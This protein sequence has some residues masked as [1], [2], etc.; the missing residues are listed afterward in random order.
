MAGPQPL[1]SK[2]SAERLHEMD[3]MLQD[4]SFARCDIAKTF[5]LPY[6]SVINRMDY[7][8]I[9]RNTQTPSQ[10]SPVKD[11]VTIDQQ[12]L[13]LAMKREQ[14][15]REMER[16]KAVRAELQIRF[17][18][19]GSLILVYGVADNPLVAEANRWMQF[20]NGHGAHKLREFITSTK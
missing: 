13:D 9:K 17:E 14:L 10:H 16:L 2:L 15:E 6:S 5:D 1:W 11:L 12:L 7:L 8:G 20:L 4:G 3:Q 19:D 18:R